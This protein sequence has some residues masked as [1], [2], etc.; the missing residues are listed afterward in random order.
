MIFTTRSS[1][2]AQTIYRC[3]L[4]KVEIWLGLANPEGLMVVPPGEPE[5]QQSVSQ[6]QQQPQPKRDDE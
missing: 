5:L 6:Q 4:C 1:L 3:E 2:P